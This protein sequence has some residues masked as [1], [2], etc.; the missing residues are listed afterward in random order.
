MTSDPDTTQTEDLCV[1]FE[2][3]DNEL[4]PGE[5]NGMRKRTYPA[6]LR[7]FKHK[8]NFN[9]DLYHTRDVISTVPDRNWAEN[10]SARG[11]GG[12]TQ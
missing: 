7:I 6:V 10:V 5:P 11:G 2:F 3:E 8:E 12:P 9:P 4:L 1:Q